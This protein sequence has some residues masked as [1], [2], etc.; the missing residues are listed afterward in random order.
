MADIT[1]RQLL[2]K[3]GR[4]RKDNSATAYRAML[5]AER[6]LEKA[7]AEYLRTKEKEEKA[8]ELYRD[9]INDTFGESFDEDL[10]LD[11]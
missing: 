11:M 8:T 4:E 6:A 1:V 7:K 9:Y 10:L 5:E 3:I 2:N